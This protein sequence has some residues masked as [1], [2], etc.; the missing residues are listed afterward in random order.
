ME[1][2][3]EAISRILGKESIVDPATIGHSMGGYAA[4]A[5]AEKYGENLGGLGLFHS[6]GYADSNQKK[7]RIGNVLS[8]R[9]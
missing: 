9:Q 5:Y 4:L 2:M 8:M 7:K 3:A 6:T 1:D